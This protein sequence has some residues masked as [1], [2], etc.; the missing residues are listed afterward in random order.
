MADITITIQNDQVPTALKGFLKIHPNLETV[1]DPAWTPEDGPAPA[2]L[3]KY[4]NAQWAKEVLR[5]MLVRDVRRGLQL[6]A[7]E[8]V[9]VADLDNIAT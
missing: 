8:E 4:T 5:R 1:Q 7:N 3:P 2:M 6:I 9:T